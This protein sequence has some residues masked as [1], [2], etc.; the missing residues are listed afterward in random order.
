MGL[1]DILN[2]I[3]NGPR[4]QPNPN[5]GHSDTVNS[6]VGN[7]PNRSISPNDLADALGADKINALVSQSG[8]SRGDLLQG[9][10]QHL[11]EVINQ[12]TL[13]GRL[14]SEQEASRMI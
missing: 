12:L 11:P 13:E 2:G 7:G 10:S 1:M 14:P 4:G 3:Q 6:W 8:L 9:L 5:S